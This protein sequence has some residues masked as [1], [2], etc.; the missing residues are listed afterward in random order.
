MA[1]IISIPVYLILSVFIYQ[2]IA[3]GTSKPCQFEL[4][5]DGICTCT[6]SYCDTLELPVAEQTENGYSLT[7]SSKDG[8]RFDTIFG[9]FDSIDDSSNSSSSLKICQT[10]KYQ[11]MI[12][13]GGALSDSSSEL[14]DQMSETL[15]NNF[16]ESIYSPTKGAGHTITRVP[17]GGTDFSDKPWGYNETPK[18]DTE[19]RNMSTLDW[20][21]ERRINQIKAARQIVPELEESMRYMFCPWS[22]VPWMK[23][24]Y[25]WTGLSYLLPDYYPTYALYLVK[26]VNL[27][28]DAGINAWGLSTGNEPS[29]SLYSSIPTLGWD[30]YNQNYWV[31]EYLRPTMNDNNMNDVK[32]IG[33]DDKRFEVIAFANG[34][35]NSFHDRSIPNIDIFAIHWYGDKVSSMKAI[36]QVAELYD[37]PMLMTEGCLGTG[38][39]LVEDDTIRGPVIGA[40]NRAAYYAHDLIENF[41]HNIGGYVDWNYVLNENGGPSYLKASVDAPMIFNAKDQILIKQ[42]IYYALAHFS[43]F[44]RS[45]CTRV[46]SELNN[47]YDIEA[48]S[49]ACTENEMVV[50]LHNLGSVA[51]TITLIDDGNNGQA[52]ITVDA[53]SINTLTYKINKKSWKKCHSHRRHC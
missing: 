22:A 18:N 21:D 16:Y 25:A 35:Q 46:K 39:R 41:Q 36:D 49:F 2:C 19:L 14:I 52:Q 33:I 51:Q 8:K 17:I 43:K 4:T 37:K 45:D 42:P 7:T 31:N 20:H 32:I 48:I 6:D 24:N 27:W 10:T 9:T 38:A 29:N 53:N 50:I 47:L 13:F 28:I 12:G 15:R 3:I 11:K 5:G 23:S 26:A 1:K 44:L 34:Y 40:W 30:P